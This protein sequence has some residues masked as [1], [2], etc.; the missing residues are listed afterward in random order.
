MASNFL[1]NL[2]NAV[3][4]GEFNSE[5]AKKINEVHNAAEK[6]LKE[7]NGDISKI[8]KNLNKKIENV[9]GATKNI[10]KED[11]EKAQLEYNAKMKA[12]ADE[13]KRNAIIASLIDENDHIINNII[14]LYSLIHKTEKY[15]DEKDGKN[16]KLFEKINEFKEKYES[17]VNYDDL[18]TP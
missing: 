10:S 1:D 3:E 17:I 4:N 11:I 13:E 18:I 12:L 15:Y 8:E 9:S 7:A 5:T 2:K 6:K 16:K 14:D